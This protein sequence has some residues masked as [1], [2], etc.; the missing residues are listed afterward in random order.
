MNIGEVAVTV[1]IPPR[2]IRYYEAIGLVTPPRRTATGYR[3]YSDDDV[4]ILAFVRGARALGFS[5]DACRELVVLQRDEHRMSADVLAVA[6]AHLEE[7][8]LQRHELEGMMR[9]LQQ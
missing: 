1:G 9:S 3:A 7:L 5:I 8:E 4:R 6:R 2:T